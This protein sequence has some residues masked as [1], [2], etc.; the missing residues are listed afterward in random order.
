MSK[1]DPISDALSI[2]L[3]AEKANKKTCIVHPVSKLLREILRVMQEEKYIGDYEFVDDNKGGKITVN[4]LGKI[5]KCGSIKPR[6]NFNSLTLEKH[7]K[8][9]LPAKDFGVIIVTTSKGVMTHINA[10]NKN[11]GGGLLAYVY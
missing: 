11:H 2:I 5:N 4:L 7:E 10:K 8:R 9:L 3:N 6:F 1:Q